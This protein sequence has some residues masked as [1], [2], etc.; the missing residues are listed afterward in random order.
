MPSFTSVFEDAT[1]GDNQFQLGNGDFGWFINSGADNYGQD[2]YERPV[3]QQFRDLTIDS[4]AGDDAELLANVGNDVFGTTGS[5]VNYFEYIDIERARFGF[6]NQF[7][8]FRIELFGEQKVGSD[9]SVT[10]DFG[11][12]TF[13]RVRL[14]EDPDGAFSVMLS[15]ELQADYQKSEN[16]GNT[17]DMFNDNNLKAAKVFE[18]VDGDVGGPGGIAVTNENP[19]GLNGFSLPT[20]DDGVLKEPDSGTEILYTRK[21]IGEPWVEFAFNYAE[22]NAQRGTNLDPTDGLPYL[23]FEANRGTKDNQNYLWNDKYTLDEAGSPYVDVGGVQGSDPFAN[24]GNC[25]STDG[26]FP[27]NQTENVYELDTLTA[28]VSTPPTDLP[29]P[30]TLLIFGVGLAALA[31]GAR[32]KMVA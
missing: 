12:G 9:G 6:D 16:Q 3:I 30:G 21:V 25:S 1:T 20:V 5:S 11:E 14:G 7:M 22:Y 19:G 24:I 17:T 18:D 4:A 26:D 2:V 28:G 27:C 13:Y 29:A 23:V 10:D 15:G 8:Y 32:G 31:F